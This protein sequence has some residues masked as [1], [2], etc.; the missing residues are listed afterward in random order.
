MIFLL[1]FSD[2]KSLVSTCSM[3]K[4][5]VISLEAQITWSEIF[6]MLAVVNDQ[7]YIRSDVPFL[8]FA[9]RNTSLLINT[10]SFSFCF[11]LFLSSLSSLTMLDT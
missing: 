4:L 6:M 1:V 10:N 8:E 2:E 5:R 3:S 7:S 9:S 11:S